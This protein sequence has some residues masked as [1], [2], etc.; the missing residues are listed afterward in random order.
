M[1]NSY[2]RFY[3]GRNGSG[4]SYTANIDLV[5][6][7]LDDKFIISIDPKPERDIMTKN[8]GGENLLIGSDAKG[9]AFINIFDVLMTPSVKSDDQDRQNPLLNQY[10]SNL[11]SIATL[12]SLNVNDPNDKIV[13]SCFNDVQVTVYEKQFK[14][15]TKTDFMKV[16][17]NKFPLMRDFYEES[18]RRYKK[19]KTPETKAAFNKLILLMKEHAIGISAPI[20]NNYTNVD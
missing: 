12:C 5:Q 8:L 10:Q 9:A 6:D 3:Q 14:L 11:T 15:T 7:R 1:Y 2:N 17:K 13:L 4:K 16:P 18:I 20:F 19:E